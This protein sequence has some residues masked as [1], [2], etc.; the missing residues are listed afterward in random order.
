[1]H[2]PAEALR[3]SLRRVSM[4]GNARSNKTKDSMILITE[5]CGTLRG[6]GNKIVTIV[7]LVLRM[8]MHFSNGLNSCFLFDLDGKLSYSGIGQASPSKRILSDL[9]N[10]SGFPGIQLSTYSDKFVPRSGF[11]NKQEYRRGQ[12]KAS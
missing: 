9:S 11:L 6:G 10:S 2:N 12:W 5:S 8:N 7:G 4:A 3:W 1:M